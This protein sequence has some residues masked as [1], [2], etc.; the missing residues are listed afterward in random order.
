MTDQFIQFHSYAAD[1]REGNNEKQDK[2]KQ[3]KV[4]AWITVTDVDFT[5][6]T[7]TT[8]TSGTAGSI[9]VKLIQGSTTST[10]FTAGSATSADASGTTLEELG[11]L[12]EV[13]MGT[14]VYETS[15]TIQNTQDAGSCTDSNNTNI[16]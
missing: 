7:L 4:V 12:S 13:E 6:D 3:A 11:P 9:L 14:S 10:I 16:W 15:M 8:T 5:G 1:L 2:M